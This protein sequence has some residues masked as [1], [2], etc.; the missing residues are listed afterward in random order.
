M[1]LYNEDESRTPKKILFLHNFTLK[2][3]KLQRYLH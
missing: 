1:N 2:M 3:L